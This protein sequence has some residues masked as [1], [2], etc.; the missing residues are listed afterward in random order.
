MKKQILS[1]IL[2]L[3]MLSA[4]IPAYAIDLVFVPLQW[5]SGNNASSLTVMMYKD[6]IHGDTQNVTPKDVAI[7][8]ISAPVWIPL[9]A[10]STVF[11]V[12]G[13]DGQ[14]AKQ[15]LT[16]E[17]LIQQGY[18]TEEVQQFAIDTQKLALSLQGR[19]VTVEEFKET[20]K[21]MN[22]SAST[23]QILGL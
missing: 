9:L 19:K 11:T 13:E 6:V 20:V 5:A 23:N 3:T 17:N 21:A 16:A 1:A 22:F 12:L 2:S 18:T 15:G 4:A 7:N 10:L 14:V 8:I